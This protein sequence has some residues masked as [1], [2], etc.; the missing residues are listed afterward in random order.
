MGCICYRRCKAEI[1]DNV[2]NLRVVFDNW[3]NEYVLMAG[4]TATLDV[5]DVCWWVCSFRCHGIVPS[6][7]GF[8][9]LCH[10]LYGG[11]RLLCILLCMYWEM[12]WDIHIDMVTAYVYMVFTIMQIL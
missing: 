10:V 2:R 4:E 1:C 3:K 7:D 5:V 6:G 9:L 11:C 12:T 8:L